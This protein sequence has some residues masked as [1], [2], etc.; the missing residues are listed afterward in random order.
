MTQK[1]RNKDKQRQKQGH[2][3]RR[4]HRHTHAHAHRHR[5]RPRDTIPYRQ[6]GGTQ[7]RSQTTVSRIVGGFSKPSVRAHAL[8]HACESRRDACNEN[9]SSSSPSTRALDAQSPVTPS[10]AEHHPSFIR[11]Q[12]HE[13]GPVR[14]NRRIQT[15]QSVNFV[16][17]IVQQCFN[18][19][20]E[21][22]W[23]INRP[24]DPVLLWTHQSLVISQRLR[25]LNGHGLRGLHTSFSLY[26]TFPTSTSRARR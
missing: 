7:E 13:G 17:R 12:Q 5:K 20:A 10:L 1:Y 25:Q 14:A 18:A 6:A 24:G 9:K 16:R 8:R 19:C 3:H 21:D 22:P 11:N 26:S 2:R 15:M 23:G 4:K